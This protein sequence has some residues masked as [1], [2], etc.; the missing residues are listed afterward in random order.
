MQLRGEGVSGPYV[1]SLG[2]VA[3]TDRV[4]IETRAVDNAQR[5]VSRQEL[6]RFV[7]YQIDYDHGTLLLKQPLPATDAYGNPT[8]IVATFEANGGGARS[9]VWGARASADAAR[10]LSH[11]SLDT[12]RIGALWVQ[13]AQTT[14]SQHLA[15]LDF[16]AA[17]R[18]WLD[19]GAE[20]TQTRN[21]DSS[22]IAAA[23]HGAAKFFG[24]ALTFR[25][26]WMQIGNGFANPANLM[27]QS[28]S[29][30]LTLGAKAKLGATELRLEHQR[31]RFDA[32]DV[33][34]A[35]T[36]A[37]VVQSLPAKFKIES[38]VV[39]D[40]YAT[41]TAN[42]RSTAGEMKVTWS[43]LASVDLFTDAHHRF[44]STGTSAQPDF[45]GAGATYRVIP[46]V[47]LEV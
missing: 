26:T 46:G 20:L 2:I 31:Q 3:G 11:S 47:A 37:G 9:T 8:F 7:D 36:L 44:S 10:Y 15:G 18:G 5:V 13:D 38:D 33:S 43:P 42:D 1:L 40:S 24:D 12:L 16:R 14:G 32:A 35:R 45:V 29:S 23:A 27:L 4:V 25:G 41:T 30:D 39:G 22:G 17:W 19:V 6:M 34:R 28:G 21:P